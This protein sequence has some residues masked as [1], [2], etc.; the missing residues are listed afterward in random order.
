MEITQGTGT[1][2][3]RAS[4][5]HKI[6]TAYYITKANHFCE[7]HQLKKFRFCRNIMTHHCEDMQE[8]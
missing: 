3:R 7:N 8:Q 2:E 6:S 5:F 4:E 1:I